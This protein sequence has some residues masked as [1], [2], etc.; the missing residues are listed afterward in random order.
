MTTPC[1]LVLTL[2]P[3]L[4]ARL[5]ARAAEGRLDAREWARRALLGELRRPQSKAA[6]DRRRRQAGFELL[7]LLAGATPSSPAAG[8]VT[9]GGTHGP[10][11]R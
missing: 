9:E 2:N 4:Y 11:P 7:S 8:P 10:H 6:Q 5:E 1:R 3:E